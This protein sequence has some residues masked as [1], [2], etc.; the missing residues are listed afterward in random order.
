MIQ[1]IKYEIVSNILGVAYFRHSF[2]RGM[3]RK[4]LCSALF[5]V[6]LGLMTTSAQSIQVISKQSR[7]P[8]HLVT[9]RSA[10]TE[11]GAIT[12]ENGRADISSLLNESLLIFNH[13]SFRELKLSIER[14]KQLN[15]LVELSEAI[16]QMDDIVISASKWEQNK[17]EV[18]NKI[19]E[20]TP[21]DISFA[22][23]PTTADALALSGQVF[24]QKSQLGGGSPII[25][26][27]SANSVLIVVDGVRMNNAIFRSGNL[28]NVINLDANIL[29]GSEVVFGPAS[30]LY[31]SDAL[32]G[33]M[34]FHTKDPEFTASLQTKVSGLGFLR[35]ASAAQ[36]STGHFQINYGGPI[37][38]SLTSLTVSR[39]GDLRTGSNRTDKFPDF[40]KR[41][42]YVERINDMDVVTTN[43]NVNKQVFSGYDQFNL[44]QK[45]KWRFKSSD[46]SY[47][48]H[49]S[50]SSD[51]P[52]YD[53]LILK[54]NQGDFQNAEWYYG[55][56]EWQMHALK[57]G[58]FESNKF[59][60]EAKLTTSYQ[61][62]VE[63]RHSREF[64]ENDLIS[65]TERVDVFAVNADFD[66]EI[67]ED[68]QLFYG[69]ELIQNKV[70]SRASSENIM[71][72]VEGPASTR[73]PDGGSTY[74]SAAVYGSYKWK[75]NPQLIL[76][77]GL[78]YSFVRLNS[79]FVDKTFFNF[80]FD[81][82]DLSNGAVNGSL[83]M[84]YLPN[85]DSKLSF[86]LS[87][88][89]R[90]P[91]I[92][93]V[94]KVFDSEPGN[95]VVPNPNLEPEFS[96]NGEIGF[97]QT[98]NKQIK[99]ESVFYYTLLRNALVRRNFTFNGQQ[100][101][102]FDGV[103][104]Q[105]QAEV[106]AGRAYIF[107]FSANLTADLGN[108]F[109]MKGTVTYT[110]G[111]DTIDQ[112]PLRHVVPVF[113]ELSF[114]YDN[115]I[116]KAEVFSRFSG[117]IAFEDLAPSEQN[118]T[119]LYTSDGALPWSTLNL[120]TSLSVNEMFD[121]NLTLENILDTHYR[122]YSSGISAPGFNAI[123][124]FRVKF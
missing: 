66:K 80:P 29:E 114:R 16:T 112:I 42:E 63:S 122:P 68:Q 36:E 32:G 118:K 6:I 83:G 69:F 22:Q 64:Q 113:G 78:R 108:N 57:A 71:T 91:N 85:E 116:F 107:G 46:I 100:Q 43:D 96:Y 44:M 84:V 9:I 14:I 119:H 55:P 97:A 33:V 110:E 8:I 48:A 87:S 12:D 92:D 18:P 27:F 98:I 105:V 72:E 5:I 120:R 93:D 61:R 56:Q 82:I 19:V 58:F 28:Q 60:S 67:T 24:I 3:T 15:Y 52:R 10:D 106:N 124:A 94:G 117:G 11:R 115:E 1:Y 99:I 111:E 79:K 2:E 17:N 50:T 53:R 26:G 109:S 40:G 47:A 103:L 7:Q 62:F 20:V 25:R 121:I 76:N 30:V 35:F 73:Y 4:L 95:V 23:P 101:I 75:I 45:L 90:S 38:S 34:D 21:A 54:D 86:V 102:L 37:F 81:A 59:F 51:V 88:G 41:L 49:V 65:R 104:S 74:S 89:F 31:G 13:P 70:K 123:V 77:S 39:F